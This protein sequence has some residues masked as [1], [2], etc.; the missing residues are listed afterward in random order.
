[1]MIRNILALAFNDLAVALKNKTIYLILFIPFFVFISL[2]LID[3]T[4]VDVSKIKIGL[5]QKY[6]YDPKITRSIKAAEKIIEV[7]W[8]LNEVEGRRL[9]KEKKVDGVL[10]KNEK[11][12]GSNALLVLKKDSL[13]TL[14]IVEIFS[15]MQKAAE[16]N[17]V[18]WITDIK[19]LHKGGIQ[20]ETL[21][22]WILMLVLLVGFIVLPAQVAEEKEKKLLLALLQTPI[23]E[24]EWLIAK[25]ITGMVLMSIAILFL[26]VL[27]KF[28]LANLLDYIAL[29]TFGSFCF[30]AYGIFLGF[31]CRNQASARTL[32]VVFYLPHL[33]P[34]ALSDFSQKLTAVAPVLPSYQFYNPLKYLLLED[35][36]I[37]SLPFE[38]IYL[39]LTGSFLFYLSYLL[40]RKRWLM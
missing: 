10:V 26:H 2:K 3:R 30:S 29:I 23:R 15:A 5:I 8:L 35:G 12:P 39:F 9:L 21:P 13:Q 20:R 11:A 22:T 18:S 17:H 31:L 37:T 33:L 36:R 24:V 7:T 28:G 14:A 1:M 16:G 25:L 32:G 4:D 27:G 19:M 40:M 38:L 34:S 6:P